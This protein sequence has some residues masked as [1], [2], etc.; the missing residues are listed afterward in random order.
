MQ[1]IFF[2]ILLEGTF[3]FTSYFHILF[4]TLLGAG[5]WMYMGV[6]NNLKYLSVMTV[7]RLL[8][9]LYLSAVQVSLIC[10][11]YILKWLYIFIIDTNKTDSHSNDQFYIEVH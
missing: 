9:L 11:S 6:H 5:K 1:K 8:H 2:V 4:F 7:F 3:L 10:D